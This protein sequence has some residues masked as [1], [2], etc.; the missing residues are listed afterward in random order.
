LTILS[1]LNNELAGQPLMAKAMSTA[2][3]RGQTDS[4]VTAN[5]RNGRRS[6]IS[7][8]RKE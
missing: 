7:V 8:S 4:K 2:S 5:L 1:Q 3:A 6:L